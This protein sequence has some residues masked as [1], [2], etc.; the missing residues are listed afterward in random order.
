MKKIKYL[1][2][3]GAALLA[4][5]AC[6]NSNNEISE[7]KALSLYQLSVAEQYTLVTE[8]SSYNS[9]M[10]PEV[11]ALFEFGIFSNIPEFDESFIAFATPDNCFFGQAK[12]DSLKT[13][14]GYFKESITYTLDGKSLTAEFTGSNENEDYGIA[15]NCFF[16]YTSAG[17]IKHAQYTFSYVVDTNGDGKSDSVNVYH[18][19]LTL[20]WQKA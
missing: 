8:K 16:K 9:D 6:G 19:D 1:P 18:G 2:L 7:V 20:V 5:T 4:L 15:M 17:L 12:A 11:K 13:L 10:D 14:A 3:F